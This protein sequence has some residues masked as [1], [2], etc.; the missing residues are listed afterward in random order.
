MMAERPLGAQISAMLADR[1]VEVIFGIP[2][3]HNIELYRSL[4][5]SGL[6]HVLARHEQGAAFMADGYA[7][8]TGKPGVA[9][10][11][12]GPGLTNAMT[13]MG[14]AYSDSVP[15]L[16]ISSCLNRADLGMGRGRLHEMNDQEIAGGT[17]SDWSRTAMDAQS[18]YD[19]ID[20]A[21][22]EFQTGR[23]RTKHI[24]IPIEVLG[25][26]A[27]PP[28]PAASLAAV[29]SVVSDEVLQRVSEAKRPL[30]VFGGGARHCADLARR[31]TDRLGAASFMT[32]AGR[33][34]VAPGAPLSYGSYL[35]RPESEAVI[36]SADVVVAIG[37][38]LS[39]TD[40]WRDGLGH[41]GL[42]I[43]VDLDPAELS[44]PGALNVLCDARAFLQALDHYSEGHVAQTTWQAED[45]AAARRRW[46][47]ETDAERP[48]VVPVAEALRDI[49][50]DD[51]MIF[52][53]MTQFAYVAKEIWD[54]PAPGLWH[55]PYGFGT[56]G[57]ALPAA[58]GG[59]VAEL[60]LSL[61]ILLWDNGLL[62]EIEGSME[63]S[64]IAPVAIKAQNPDFGLLA[65]AYGLG[66]VRPVDLEGFQQAVLAALR[67]DGPTLIH[68]TPEMAG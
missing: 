15:L 32:Y 18:A 22:R 29:E 47:A 67:A 19:L 53:D 48:L 27:L 42:L 26:S 11:I 35:G 9:Y 44:D 58:I 66:Y 55:H 57:Y 41:R 8:A 43:R 61:P 28:L 25:A 3:V 4:E 50:P 64:Q 68:M 34:I 65:Q 45:V 51:A 37:T 1:G 14:Q 23:A 56:L 38:E 62:K 21:L 12:T 10:V 16:V 46:R 33:G 30:F 59:K 52:S 7:R 20:R 31:V 17:V 6:H 2:G 24:Q 54:M 13:A 60:G 40:L 39:E 49:L 63:A 5:A 36:A